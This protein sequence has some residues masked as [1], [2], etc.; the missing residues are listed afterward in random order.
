MET[1]TEYLGRFHVSLVHFPIGLLITAAVI[2]LVGA[3]R[4]FESPTV[5]AVIMAG[6]GALAAVV[7][8]ALGWIRA[9]D[10]RHPGA[11][12]IVEWHRWAGL[13][14]TIVALITFALGW[15]ALR[16]R[17]ALRWPFRALLFS[18]A[19]IIGLAGH[20]GGALI[21]GDDYYNLPGAEAP[22]D[23]DEFEDE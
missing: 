7:A 11:E 19:I 8:S 3:L 23:D 16:G 9:D 21:Y 18:T 6:C 10:V 15:A 22:A 2:E 5:C 4:R 12:H 1:L 14:G 20:W 17:L 13:V